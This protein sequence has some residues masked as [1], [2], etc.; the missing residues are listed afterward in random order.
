[1]SKNRTEQPN[2]ASGKIDVLEKMK[3]LSLVAIWQVNTK[4]V[5]QKPRT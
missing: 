5:Q 1:M 3:S 2:I 4:E